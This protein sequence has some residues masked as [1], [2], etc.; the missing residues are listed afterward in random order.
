MIQ[1]QEKLIAALKAQTIT[2]PQTAYTTTN[3]NY[4]IDNFSFDSADILCVGRR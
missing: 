3:V 2:T 1:N 4:F